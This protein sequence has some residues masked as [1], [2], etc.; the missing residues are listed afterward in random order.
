MSKAKLF[1]FRDK[2]SPVEVGQ[3]VLVVNCNRRGDP[4]ELVIEKVG[5][6]LIHL[7]N[8][9]SFYF[10]GSER[11]DYGHN[12]IYSSQEGY[13]M[14]LERRRISSHIESEFRYIGGHKYSLE[15]LRKVKELLDA[16]TSR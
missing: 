14:E 4:A 5:R 8:G 16:E 13:D 9:M 11:S 3:R 12:T 10:N 1:N 7:N 6:S 15:T 2:Y